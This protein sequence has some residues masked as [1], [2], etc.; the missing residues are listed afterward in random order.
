MA[1]VPFLLE[2]NYSAGGMTFLQMVQRLRQESGTSG[3]MP[4]TTINQV[5]DIKSLCDWIGTSW[6]DIQNGKPDWFFMRQPVQFNSVAGQQSYTATQASISSFGNF[7]LD[8]F[9]QFSVVQGYGS[10]QRLNFLP[11]DQFRDLYQFGTMRAAQQMP[12]TFT[13]D[14]SKNFLLGPAPDSVYTINGEGYAMPT[15][16][17]LD[18]DRPTMPPQFHMAIVWR[19]LMYYGQKEAAAEAYS[20]G[21]NEYLR[22]MSRLYADQ[23]PTITFGAPLA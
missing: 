18:A 8:S 9:R 14:Q 2:P 10:E 12:V 16:F 21:Q 17:T 20:H 22:L 5:G 6:M 13:V 4:T 15:E 23:M 11:F 7:K 3:A 19:A 1:N